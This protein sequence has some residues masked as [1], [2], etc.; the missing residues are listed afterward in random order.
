MFSKGDPAN[1]LKRFRATLTMRQG[2]SEACAILAPAHHAL[3]QSLNDDGP[4]IEIEAED[5]GQAFVL[6]AEIARIDLHEAAEPRPGDGDSK[7]YAKDYS[8][9]EASDARLVLGVS[10]DATK[11]EVHAKWREL[12]K[13]Y[14]PDRLTA[15]GLP[16]EM[17]RH[18]DRVLARI[19]AAYRRLKNEGGD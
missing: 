10:V 16:D 5:G 18:A 15:L 19:N 6:K 8:R 2:R 3:R 17:L 9:F 12:A 1:K 7:A 13:A 11:E 4:F 14:H